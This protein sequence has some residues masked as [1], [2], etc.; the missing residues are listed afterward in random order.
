MKKLV[1]LILAIGVIAAIAGIVLSRKPK[2]NTGR[3][4]SPVFKGLVKKAM[5]GESELHTAALLG[6][7]D[8][9]KQLLANGADINHKNSSGSTPLCMAVPPG[10][11]EVAEFLIANGADLNVKDN[12]GYTPLH[13]AVMGPHPEM[14]KLLLS[15]GA[16]VN[17]KNKDGETPLM[18]AQKLLEQKIGKVVVGRRLKACIKLL[19]EHKE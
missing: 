5:S 13:L 7:I 2:A 1:F 6:E 3:H 11:K 18:Y 4:F 12:K 15:N 19:R 14:V 8:E 9:V 10:N 16:D 17:S